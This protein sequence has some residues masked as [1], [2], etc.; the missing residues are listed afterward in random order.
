MRTRHRRCVLQLLLLDLPCD[1]TG[2]GV[3]PL[4]ERRDT[5]IE[6]IPVPVQSLDGRCQPVRLGV[7]LPRESFDLLRL[8]GEFCG[9]GLIP[10]QCDG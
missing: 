10:L 4:L 2:Q 1:R 6:T 9:R 7:I 3:E 5:G 8:P